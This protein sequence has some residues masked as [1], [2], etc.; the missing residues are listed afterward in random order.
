MKA[1]TLQAIQTGLL[2]ST[3][4]LGGCASKELHPHDWALEVQNAE[5][6]EAH[7]LLAEHYEDV[8]KTMDADAEEER[9]MLEQYQR[10]PY[11]YGKQILDLKARAQAMIMDFEKAA[12]ESRK[13][14]E[15]HRKFAEEIK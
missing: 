3:L 9:R 14:A 11:K 10:Q 1:I 13:M 8:A 12:Q 4:A 2:A 7:N 6:R 5:T 15:Y